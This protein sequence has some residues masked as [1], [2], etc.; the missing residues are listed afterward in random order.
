MALSRSFS[1]LREVGTSLKKYSHEM[2]WPARSAYAIAMVA[3]RTDLLRSPA[4]AARPGFVE[5]I[6][7]QTVRTKRLAIE[8]FER[9]H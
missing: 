8:I 6:S 7:D 3:A 1:D 9:F 5:N 2:G 4:F